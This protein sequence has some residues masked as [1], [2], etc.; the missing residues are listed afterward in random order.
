MAGEIVYSTSLIENSII[1]PGSKSEDLTSPF[2]FLEFITRTRVD[3]GPEEYNKFYLLYLKE[4]NE[5]KNEN[6]VKAATNTTKS[7]VEF[8]KEV[9]LTY[10]TQQER[11]FLSTLDFNDPVDLDIIIPFYA[12]KIRDIVLFYKEKRDTGKFIIDRN[13]IKGSE[14][15][16]EK[17]L[18]ESIYNFTFASED[19]PQYST[20]ALTLS[21]LRENLAI[22]VLE[23]VDIYGNYFDIPRDDTQFSRTNTNDIDSSLYFDDPLTIFRSEVFLT[24]IPL[25]INATINYDNICNPENPLALLENECQ[26]TTGL[27]ADQRVELKKRLISKYAGVDFYYI[28]TTVTPAVSGKLFAAQNPAANIENLQ[29][30][31]TPTVPSGFNKLLRD[32]GLFFTPDKNGLFKINAPSLTY[33]ID[34]QALESDKIYVFPDPSIYGNVSLNKQAAYPIVHI[35]DSRDDIRN[36][37]S[38]LIANDPY[39][40]SSD[41]T[42]APYFVKEQNDVSGLQPDEELLLNFKDLYNEGYITKYQTDIYGNEYALFKD[43]FGFTFEAPT[44]TTETYILNLLLNGHVFFDTFEG[45]NFD[46]SVASVNGTTIRSGLTSHTVDYETAPAFPLSGNP[47]YLYFREFIPYLELNTF[48]TFNFAGSMSARELTVGLRDGGNFTFASGDPLPDPLSADSANW[49]APGQYYYSTLYEAGVASLSPPTRA[50]ISTTPSLTANFTLDVKYILSGI[51]AYS[52]DGGYFTDT[53]NIGRD[54]N[55]DTQ[56]T[57]INDI[58][59]SSTTVVSTLT[60]DNTL[61]SIA[62]RRALE[63]KIFVKKQKYSLSAPLSVTLNNT[64]DK[65][66]QAVRNQIYGSPK[67]FDIIYDTVVVETPNYLVID[68]VNFENN[69]FTKP[70]T[71]NIVF[72]NEGNLL[73][74][75]SNRF[76]NEKDRTLT[77]CVF[78]VLPTLSATNS[79]TIYPTIYQYNISD[80]KNIKL[81]PSSTD[82]TSLSSL[83][84]LSSFTTNDFNLNFV[85]V[86]RPVLSY[87]SLNNLY[88]L[89]YTCFDNNNFAYIFDRLFDITTDGVVFL[90]NKLY[91]PSKTILTTDFLQNNF[92]FVNAISGSS[93]ISSQGVLTI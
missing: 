42:F 66:S 44:E 37:S 8:L 45:F 51:D 31:D 76:F 83:F 56:Y 26:D 1:N 92:T 27:T 91:K 67:D 41:Q 18:Y 85:R 34:T 70:A 68:K 9:T 54:F 71:A 46:Y 20:T 38:S 73:K 29:T 58:L 17:A 47:L 49:P 86:A 7:Y 75:F 2:S 28:D 52:Y 11:R 62:E 35:Y 4:W 55:Y 50:I 36:I 10:T 24:E 53:L 22:D 84:S 60:G 80:R 32:V 13:K 48:G 33:S 78:D 59:P 16:I 93:T 82:V 43:R 61:L 79:K 88:K 15:S 14:V 30:V 69:E 12:E 40:R 65:Y 25:A 57:Y 63:G 39:V 5:A 23:Y 89:T 87:N 3:Y 64:F 72:N 21:S 81:Y 90:K 77:Y 19:S 74:T 6:K